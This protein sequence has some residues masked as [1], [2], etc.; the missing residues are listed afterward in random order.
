MSTK[1]KIFTLAAFYTIALFTVVSGYLPTTVNADT[2][3]DATMYL[4]FV[5]DGLGFYKVRNLDATP[6]QFTYDGRVLSINV[7][8][9]MIWENDADIRTFTIVSDQKLWNDQIGK[10]KVGQRIN[11]KFDKPGTYTFYIKEISSKRQTIIVNG[12]EEL[13]TATETPV[14][15]IANYPTPVPTTTYNPSYTAVRDTVSTPVST[16]VPIVR[17]TPVPV[18]KYDMP[19]VEIPLEMTPTSV[20]SVVVAALSIYITFRRKIRK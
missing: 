13:P 9:T 3:S 6:R 8:D 11:Y 4:S 19:D 5:H 12:N 1:R 10:I 7:G 17:Y 2:G 18:Q 16:A 20:A 15:T 14:A